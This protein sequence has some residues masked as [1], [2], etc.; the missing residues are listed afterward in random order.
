MIP[1]SVISP[2]R[3]LPF[4][5]RMWK[6][7]LG[8]IRGTIAIWGG[9]AIICLSVEFSLVECFYGGSVS[10]GFFLV[11]WG[12]RDDVL[13]GLGSEVTDFDVSVIREL[14]QFFIGV[15]GFGGEG[16]VVEELEVFWIVYEE[17][18]QLFVFWF[19]SLIISGKDMF[20]DVGAGDGFIVFV[21]ILTEGVGGF[22]GFGGFTRVTE[23]H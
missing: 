7:S 13:G 19:I 12:V 11:F 15:G 1:F 20:A 10:F 2:T 6:L 9:K 22:Q 5:L 17:F 8:C 18:N 14:S 16:G 23:D 3:A 21:H 4:C